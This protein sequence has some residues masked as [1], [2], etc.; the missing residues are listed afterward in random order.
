MNNLKNFLKTPLQLQK[1]PKWIPIAIILIALVGF[2]DATYVTVKH[3]QGVIPPCAIGGC[4]SVLTSSYS[5]ILG[6][7]VSLLGAIYYFI[8]ILSIFLHLDT[9]KEIFLKIPILMSVVGLIF[10]IY[11]MTVMVF[12][13]KA[14]CPYCIVSAITSTTIFIISA[15]A[16]CKNYKTNEQ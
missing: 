4:E 14:I 11:F 1:I 2:S 6:I 3:F 8:I 10:S 12:V 15:F 13:L 5:K 16:V 9:K 7:P